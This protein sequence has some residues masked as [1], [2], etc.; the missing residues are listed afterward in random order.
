MNKSI[1]ELRKEYGLT[2]SE[3]ATLTGIPLRTFKYYENDASRVGTIKY[4]YI[5]D[6]LE[7]YGLVDETHGILKREDIISACA[8]VFKDYAV[9][10]CYLFGSYSKG[11]PTESS[12]VDLLIST[13]TSG[14]RFYGLAEKLREKL[15]KNV[16][17]IDLEQ[18]SEN[19]ELL[20]EILTYGEKIYEGQ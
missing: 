8:E 1:K 17:L 9:H 10:Y 5:A 16:D 18:L 11:N 13:D 20:N 6:A 3:A 7:Q 4:N 19:R 12:D 15:K 2:Q 14:L